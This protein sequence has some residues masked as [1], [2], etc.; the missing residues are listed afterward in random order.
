MYRL[1]ILDVSLIESYV[2][3]SAIQLLSP[4]ELTRYKNYY[5][6][7]DARLFLFGRYVTKQLIAIYTKQHPGAIEIIVDGIAEKPYELHHRV[8]FSISHSG[9]YVAVAIAIK[10][11]GLDIQIHDQQDFTIFDTFFNDDE[12][13]YAHQSPQHFYRLWTA[14]ES[15]AKVTGLGFNESLKKRRPAIETTVENFTLNTTL[16]FI[17]ELQVNGAFTVSVATVE[18]IIFASELIDNL[19]GLNHAIIYSASGNTDTAV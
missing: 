4:N 18:P 11:V 12:R 16:Y 3:I 1:V 17:H 6:E 13:E 19:P 7:P 9:N 10:P 14:I 5:H 2:T 15:L 8:E